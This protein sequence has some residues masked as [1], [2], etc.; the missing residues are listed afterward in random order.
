M[1]ERRRSRRFC[2]EGVFGGSSAI[3]SMESSPFLF[4]QQAAFYNRK[5]E[6]SFTETFFVSFVATRRNLSYKL[7]LYR[8]TEFITLLPSL[9]RKDRKQNCSRKISQEEIVFE[10]SVSLCYILKRKCQFAGLG[11]HPPK[12]RYRERCRGHGEAVRERIQLRVTVFRCIN[13]FVR[14]N[15]IMSLRPDRRIRITN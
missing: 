3:R 11:F 14:A 5:S 1:P 4:C 6:G 2:L 8:F 9:S 12:A 10:F 15:R 7:R 13:I